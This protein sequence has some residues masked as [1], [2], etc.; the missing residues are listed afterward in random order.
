MPYVGRRFGLP[1]LAL[2]D[3]RLL[4]AI[5]GF[6]SG[7]DQIPVL[8]IPSRIETHSA[9][10]SELPPLKQLPIWPENKK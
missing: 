1:D 10:R 9:A 6:V 8:A 5:D 3:A 7:L 4:K 2:I